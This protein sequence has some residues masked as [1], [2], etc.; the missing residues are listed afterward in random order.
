MRTLLSKL[1]I[2]FALLPLMAAT[3]SGHVVVP[4]SASSPLSQAAIRARVE[5]N[6]AQ[7]AA[8]RA[9][10]NFD[11]HLARTDQIHWGYA[12]NTWTMSGLRQGDTILGGLPGQSSYYT[13]ASNLEASAGSRAT[14]LQ[15]L[16]VKPHPEFGYRPMVG[17]YR[18][19]RDMSAPY[20]NA[21]ANPGLGV[22][23]GQQYFIRDYT[24]H[25]QL[26]REVPLNP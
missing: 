3:A 7:S 16:Q 20:G 13:A 5:A 24:R 10:S 15:S 9:S 23:G 19:L 22:G 6:L 18:V 11:I 1:L 2:C 4:N 25:L 8:A 12:A 26:I 14:L 17:E 21:S